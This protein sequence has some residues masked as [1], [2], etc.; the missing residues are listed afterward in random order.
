MSQDRAS[1]LV[2][3]DYGGAR[4]TVRRRRDVTDVYIGGWR[5]GIYKT[6]AGWKRRVRKERAW[7]GHL[8]T[9]EYITWR[10]PLGHGYE[11]SRC[12]ALLQVG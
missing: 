4:I 11:C 9:A 5:L 2:G 8:G 10:G 1:H 3:L 6:T 7:D 12:G